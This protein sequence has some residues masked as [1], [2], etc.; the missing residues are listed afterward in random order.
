[1]LRGRNAQIL[2][3]VAFVAIIVRLLFLMEL[4]QNSYLG[5]MRISDAQG[6]HEIAAELAAG[7]L[8][9]NAPFWQPPFYPYALSFFYRVFGDD[10]LRVQ[11]LQIL[12]GSLNCVLLCRVVQL[13][14][15]Y[16]ASLIAGL[17]SALYAPM[18]LFEVQPM[19]TPTV[20]LLYIIVI[21]QL[22]SFHR[23]GGVFT[24]FTAG[25][26]T[27]AAAIAHG[28]ALFLIPPFSVW[29]AIV[30][31][32]QR[33]TWGRK[34][35]PV[36]LVLLFIIAAAL[37]PL[38]VSLRN[39]T[40]AGRLVFISNKA[41]I[42]LYIGNHPDYVEVVSRRNGFEW[43]D[44]QREILEAGVLDT[45]D[46]NSYFQRAAIKN[47]VAKPGAF[48]RTLG[49]KLMIIF[50]GAESKR[51]FAIYPLREQSLLFW[52]LLQRFDFAP[53]GLFLPT[54]LLI[55]L[56]AVGIAVVARRG[57]DSLLLQILPLVVAIGHVTGL[58]AF[59][60][61][62]RYRLPALLALIPYGA[63][64]ILFAWDLFRIRFH[65]SAVGR[66][67]EEIGVGRRL[68]ASAALMIFLAAFT[69]SSLGGYLLK[70][71]TLVKDASE[72][73][74]YQGLW[75][76]ESDR[77]GDGLSLFEASAE[78][79][80]SYPEPRFALGCYHLHLFR[81][82]A[83]ALIYF[84]ELKETLPW[85]PKIELQRRL[86]LDAMDSDVEK[87]TDGVPSGESNCQNP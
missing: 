41:G 32:R 70:Y 78:K 74:Y 73:L 43:D 68:S 38:V 40:A 50:S 64:G 10:L 12:I 61:C 52:T 35:S 55:P 37:C 22:S 79:D 46:I 23:R 4:R 31:I 83:W 7:T 16:R 44:F 86:A 53:F 80:P 60:V 17:A 1:M 39:F 59:H 56:A 5:N 28:L 87:N 47:I 71:E 51:N 49:R 75:Y 62:S 19:E 57:G 27:G 67:S 15:D 13:L 81:D 65:R 66:A 24:L 21:I 82:P 18:W 77:V 69:V 26:L 63:V 85:H 30:A 84:D 2:I 45:A 72:H 33:K 14:F 36:K 76:C 6:Y 58:A 48:L 9:G 25:L 3:L 20:I 54:G 11:L 42:N 34:Y 29:I 8:D